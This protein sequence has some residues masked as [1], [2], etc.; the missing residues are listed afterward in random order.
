MRFGQKQKSINPIKIFDIIVRRSFE[1][2]EDD[3]ITSLT[4]PYPRTY[5]QNG[6]K[7]RNLVD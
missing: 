1:I 4:N 7:R 3:V 2:S 6:G 5:A